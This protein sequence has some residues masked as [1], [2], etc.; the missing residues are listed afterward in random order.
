M[1]VLTIVSPLDGANP[2]VQVLLFDLSRCP[3]VC[4]VVGFLGGAAVLDLF[5][6]ISRRSGGGFLTALISSRMLSRIH[7]IHH[8]QLISDNLTGRSFCRDAAEHQEALLENH[9]RIIKTA[10]KLPD[11]VGEVNAAL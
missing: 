11:V 1:L 2:E 8:M 3:C 7:F 4:G 5:A 9:P 10:A 6:M